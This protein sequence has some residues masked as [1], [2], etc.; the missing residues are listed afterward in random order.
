M[1]VTDKTAYLIEGIRDRKTNRAIIHVHI[2][3]FAPGGT[4][5]NMALIQMFGTPTIRHLVQHYIHAGN[6][7]RS[8]GKPL[9]PVT[10]LLFCRRIT[11][12]MTKKS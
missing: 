7:W 1:S 5:R 12:A 11:H 10:N 6:L 3:L 4:H 8:S 9:Q 2:A